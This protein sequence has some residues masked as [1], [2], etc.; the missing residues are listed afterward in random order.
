MSENTL[1]H[2]GILGMKWGV[3]RFQN[4][5]GSYTDAGRKRYGSSTGGEAANKSQKGMSAVEKKWAQG[6]DEE[7]DRT[8]DYKPRSILTSKHK[9][10][11]TVKSMSDEELNERIDR[12][13]RES[14]YLQLEKSLDDMDPAE[15]RSTLSKTLS[16]IGNKV[17]VPAV[18]A[19][20]GIAIYKATEKIKLNDVSSDDL[21]LI[22]KAITAAL[23]KK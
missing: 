20:V 22:E 13:N 3:R 21:K 9:R 18:S 16:T 10:L 8:T 15:V 11:T 7:T 4:P 12:L 14:R 17:V 19:V 6:T 2:Y 1:K 23:T 5:D